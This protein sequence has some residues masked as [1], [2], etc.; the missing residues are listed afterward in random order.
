M[1]QLV[2]RL[3]TEPVS[4]LRLTYQVCNAL[5]ASENAQM[6]C[7]SNKTNTINKGILNVDNDEKLN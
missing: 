7:I 2:I 1:P 6:S 5:I 4:A 3:P